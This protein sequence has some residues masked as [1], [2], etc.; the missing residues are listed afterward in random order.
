MTEKRLYVIA[1]SIPGVRKIKALKIKKDKKEPVILYYKDIDGNIKEIKEVDY[2][3]IISFRKKSIKKYGDIYTDSH[4]IELFIKKEFLMEKEPFFL[5]FLIDTK[6]SKE[7]MEFFIKNI[8]IPELLI[9]KYIPVL[10]IGLYETVHASNEI[11]EI[12]KHSMKNKKD[13]LV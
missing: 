3:F 8:K 1:D 6:S 2:D 4:D 11:Q 10:K 7:Y 13:F 9:K 5:R 12:Q